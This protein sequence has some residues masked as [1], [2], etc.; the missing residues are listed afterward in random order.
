MQSA[1]RNNRRMSIPAPPTAEAIKAARLDAGL[2][3]SEAAEFVY[4]G[5]VAR[6]SEYERGVKRI[7]VARWELFLI[8]IGKSPYYRPARGVP[9]PKKASES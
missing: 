4:L 5:D 9:V 6:W 3:Q 2:T 7:D 8:K 1:L